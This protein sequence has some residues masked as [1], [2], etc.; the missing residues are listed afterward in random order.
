M[1]KKNQKN[2]FWQIAS[3]VCL[4]LLK[5]STKLAGNKT[6]RQ[7]SENDEKTKRKYSLVC[8]APQRSV[9]ETAT[10]FS[11]DDPDFWKRTP[12]IRGMRQWLLWWERHLE[13]NRRHIICWRDKRL[14]SPKQIWAR[15]A[16]SFPAEVT[17]TECWQ[18]VTLR[19]DIDVDVG[20]GDTGLGAIARHDG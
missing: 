1:K 14:R 3:F 17:H 5:H 15:K 19:N 11:S 12:S 7:I 18:A 10:W 9:C 20:V 13:R 2:K 16:D 4:A 8:T 6:N